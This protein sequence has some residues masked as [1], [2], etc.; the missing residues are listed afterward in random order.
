VVV[1]EAGE[2]RRD[3]LVDLV[4]EVALDD[5][6]HADADGEVRDRDHARRRERDP[7][8]GA[9]DARKRGG[10]HVSSRR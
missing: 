7:D 5:P 3:P 2:R 1:I 8:R 10:G 4:G 6:D 9:A